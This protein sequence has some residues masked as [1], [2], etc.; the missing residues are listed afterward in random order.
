M[1]APRE[2]LVLLL[3]P[4]RGRIFGLAMDLGLDDAEA[5]LVLLL[6]AADTLEFVL[7][8]SLNPGGPIGGCEVDAVGCGGGV[9][10]AGGSCTCSFW[11]LLI[12][13]GMVICIVR[14]SGVATLSGWPALMP[15]GM[16]ISI[17][18]QVA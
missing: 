13:G 5:L 15:S 11:P 8:D 2:S 14:P 1:P 9:P 6:D 10:S 17:R 7:L 16:V 12:P 18:S 4:A 3:P